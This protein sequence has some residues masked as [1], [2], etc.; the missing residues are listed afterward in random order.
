MA[1][2]TLESAMR[3]LTRGMG[4]QR[5]HSARISVRGESAASKVS[6]CAEVGTML[7]I[8]HMLDTL[9]APSALN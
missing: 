1:L 7:E 6:A 2:M 9:Q 8:L 3:D 5:R 4:V